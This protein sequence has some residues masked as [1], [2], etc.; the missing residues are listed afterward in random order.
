GRCRRRSTGRGRSGRS[1]VGWPWTCFA[2][3]R[4]EAERARPRPCTKPERHDLIAR[5]LYY[6][7][8]IDYQFKL[9]SFELTEPCMEKLSFTTP[10]QLLQWSIGRSPVSGAGVPGPDGVPYA[11]SPDPSRP[12]FATQPT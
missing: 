9:A 5:F 7:F 4:P 11:T 3:V 2:R 12:S 8:K 6:S 10:V 1:R